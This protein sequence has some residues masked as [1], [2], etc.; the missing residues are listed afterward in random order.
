[1]VPEFFVPMNDVGIVVTPRRLHGLGVGI[2]SGRTSPSSVYMQ[3]LSRMCCNMRGMLVDA[4]ANVT[5]VHLPTRAFHLYRNEARYNKGR[6]P[7]NRG[8]GVENVE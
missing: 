4:L 2:T 3:I 5:R 6:Q 1:M 7:L 8:R